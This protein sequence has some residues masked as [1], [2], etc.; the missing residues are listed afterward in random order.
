MTE[1]ITVPKAQSHQC[2][3]RLGEMEDGCATPTQQDTES[4]KGEGR[5]LLWRHLKP[6]LA[7]DGAKL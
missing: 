4:S 3:F 5:S 1:C 6:S 7:G 2:S